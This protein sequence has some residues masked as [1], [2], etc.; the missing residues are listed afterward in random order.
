[1]AATLRSNGCDA[2]LPPPSAQHG[3]AGPSATDHR[4]RKPIRVNV[5]PST[6]TRG[7][8][9]NWINSESEDDN[10]TSGDNSPRS[11]DARSRT[12][13][14]APAPVSDSQAPSA[15]S[16]QVVRR[17]PSRTLLPSHGSIHEARPTTCARVVC[18]DKPP[19]FFSRISLLAL[20]IGLRATT[21]EPLGFYRR[22]NSG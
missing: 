10:L 8:T 19:S 16:T 9:H 5:A 1:M 7:S 2:S 12:R 4:R 17:T 21:I 11:I 20:A 22:A 6:L 18:G 13:V 15:Q 14:Y 3:G